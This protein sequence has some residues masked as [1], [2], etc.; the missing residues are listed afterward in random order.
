[1]D[2]L[3]LDTQGCRSKGDQSILPS[4][5]VFLQPHHIRRNL[6]HFA[7]FII[8]NL[9]HVCWQVALGIATLGRVSASVWRSFKS[10]LQTIDDSWCECRAVH[11]VKLYVRNARDLH[12][13]YQDDKRVARVVTS[14]WLAGVAFFF[15][16]EFSFVCG[17]YHECPGPTDGKLAEWV[18]AR[19]TQ[20]VTSLHKLTIGF[21]PTA[22]AAENQ[23]DSSRTRL[24]VSEK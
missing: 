24:T 12:R 19:K 14:L 15:A 21:S 23:T 2:S 7:L 4:L 17:R 10:I 3:S 6:V 22:V 18:S 5:S 1:M 16:C 9:R 20:T 13:W 8:Q 11:R